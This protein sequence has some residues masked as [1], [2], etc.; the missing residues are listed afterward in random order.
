[1]PA[2]SAVVADIVNVG[3]GVIPLAFKQLQVFPDTAAKAR[4]LPFDH[5]QS[6]YYLRL[7]AKDVPGVLADV[8]ASLGKN[9]ISVSA[10]LQRESTDS[11]TVPVV[12]TTHK[13]KEGS[14]RQA[15]QEIDALATVTAPTVC[16]RILDQP[17]EFAPA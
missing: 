16:L 7:T 14:V 11:Q 2:A 3:L 8:T 13:A 1:M 15:L 12:I 5:L 4:V 6:R 17:R 10:V 9:G